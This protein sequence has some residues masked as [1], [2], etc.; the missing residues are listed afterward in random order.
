VIS[1]G[2]ASLGGEDFAFYQQCVEGC[3][4][5]FGAA[6]TVVSGPAHSD[7]F[8]FD[9]NCL[10]IGARWLAHVAWRW[11]LQSDAVT[12]TGDCRTDGR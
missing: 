6:P 5:R 11:L 9:E 3:L 4:V 2:P 10:E 12:L 1:Q 7:T 8:T